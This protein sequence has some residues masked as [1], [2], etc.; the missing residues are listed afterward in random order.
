MRRAA[1]NIPQELITTIDMMN[2]L[3]GGTSQ[4]YIKLKQFPSY[5]QISIRVPGIPH[6]NIKVEVN[7]NQLMIYY[8]TEVTS[9]DKKILFNRGLYNKNIPYFVD[10]HK[11]AATQEEDL[12]IVRLPFNEL[13]NGYHRDISVSR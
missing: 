12:L 9:Q 3:N 6:E 2:T 13:Y 1:L 5:R 4:P 8:L 11:I 7:S 10:V